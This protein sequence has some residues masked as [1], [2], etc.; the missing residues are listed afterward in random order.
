[1]GKLFP[2][3]AAAALVAVLLTALP[4]QAEPASGADPDAPDV[5]GP[6]AP[7]GIGARAELVCGRNSLY[8]LLKL[9]DR[10][11]TFAQVE[12]AVPVGPHGTNMLQLRNAA[13]DLGLADAGVYRCSFDDLVGCPKPL[14]A[15]LT[16]PLN[17]AEAGAAEAGHYV[18]VLSADQEHVTYLDGSFGTTRVS[19]TGQFRKRWSGHVL[20]PAG[21][22]GG[23]WVGWGTLAVPC[24]VVPLGLGYWR[25]RRS[26]RA[27]PA[28]GPAGPDDARGQAPDPQGTA[29]GDGLP[30]NPARESV[31]RP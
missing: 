18:V 24:L 14:I 23:S 29:Q 17:P 30:V 28:P 2:A 20:L 21:S 31:G 7:E 4:G 6:P 3:A 12:A 11:V 19:G 1:M 26:R 13:L 9:L 22:P 15:H 10:P 25:L 27:G 5:P 8:L 16:L